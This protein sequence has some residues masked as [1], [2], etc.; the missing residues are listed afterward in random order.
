[1]LS[2]QNYVSNSYIA[3]YPDDI[4]RWRPGSV[5]HTIVPLRKDCNDNIPLTVAGQPRI[6]TGFPTQSS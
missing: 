4:N 3:S 6:L 2:Q 5:H 1:M